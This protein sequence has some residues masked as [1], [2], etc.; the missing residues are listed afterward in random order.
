[1]VVY[2][3]VPISDSGIL[4]D[5]RFT[6]VGAPGTVSPLMWERFIFNEDPATTV[7]DG[8]VELSN[9]GSLADSGL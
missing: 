3:P 4:L 1:V 8:Q 9:A 6:A 2:G 7:T 5:L